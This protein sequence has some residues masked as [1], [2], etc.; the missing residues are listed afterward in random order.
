M[1]KQDEQQ[2]QVERFYLDAFLARVQEKVSMVEARP[3]GHPPDFLV[4]DAKGLL[5]LEL[6]GA[7]L[8]SD[9][10]AGSPRKEQETTRSRLLARAAD[11]YYANPS[12]PVH[13]TVDLPDGFSITPRLLA[14]HIATNRSPVVG[15]VRKFEV[16]DANGHNRPWAKIR[17]RTLPPWFQD[18][19]H[20]QCVNN[21]IGWRGLLSR[22]QVQATIDGKAKKIDRYRAATARVGL[23]IHVDRT[24]SSG[25]VAWEGGSV[26]ASGFDAVWLYLHPERVYRLH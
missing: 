19:R 12:A 2:Q 21:A 20:W 5:G 4:R 24:R 14:L 17:V 6:T 11:C 7:Y 9:Q 18:Y 10:A 8:G 13:V 23:L 1:S 3:R 15:T 16:S 25:M 26:S 22:D